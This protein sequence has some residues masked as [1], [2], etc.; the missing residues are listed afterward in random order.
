M[1]LQRFGVSSRLTAMRWMG[2]VLILFCAPVS[3]QT[4]GTFT[5]DRT[6]FTSV[7]EYVAGAAI[8]TQIAVPSN[9]LV[10]EAFRSAVDEMLRQSPTFRRQCLRIAAEPRVT[11]RLRPEMLPRRSDVRATTHFTRKEGGW[12]R[13]DIDI[14]IFPLT[15]HIELIAHEIEHVIEQ[16]DDVDL[17]SFA[18]MPGTGVR[19][20]DSNTNAFETTRA[21]RVGRKVAGEMRASTLAWL[22]R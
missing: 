20:L 7:R 5:L 9:L 15:Q 21:V 19:T 17:V 2:F 13:A 6:S 18:S 8:P 12:M 22:G 16:L 11:V 3:A 10:S 1:R 14:S 4:N